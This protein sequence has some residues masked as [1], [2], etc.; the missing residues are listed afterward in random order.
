M[1]RKQATVLAYGIGYGGT[2][3]DRLNLLHWK[4]PTFLMPV[5]ASGHFP[6]SGGPQV[7]RDA[8]GLLEAGTIDVAPIVSH[9]H[10]GLRALAA[11]FD[12]VPRDHVKGVL[13]L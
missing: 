8:L 2:S 5:G 12:G 13:V 10:D 9:R 3:L 11:A 7:Y 6:R 4:E 1:I